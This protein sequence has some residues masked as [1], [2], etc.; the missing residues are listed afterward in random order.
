VRAARAQG[1]EAHVVDLSDPAG[2]RALGITGEVVVAGELL[3]HIDRPGPFLEAMHS[4]T[5]PEGELILTTPNAFRLFGFVAIAFRR[6]IVNPDH[7]AYYSWYTLGNLLSRHG[8]HAVIAPYRRPPAVRLKGRIVFGTERL[9]TRIFPYLGHGLVAVARA[10]GE[11][12]SIL[13]PP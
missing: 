5:G 1:Y 10:K 8:W 7:V 6:E 12:S 3:E 9:L 4:L 2:T 11:A 13:G